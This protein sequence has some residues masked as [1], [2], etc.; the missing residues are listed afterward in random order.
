VFIVKNYP[1]IYT[2][3]PAK[4]NLG[5]ILSGVSLSTSRPTSV[6]P[7]SV[8]SSEILGKFPEIY[9]NFSRNYWTFIYN[10]V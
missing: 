2:S 7:G 6:F 9:S 3:R 8:V 10:F 1:K 4:K 5:L